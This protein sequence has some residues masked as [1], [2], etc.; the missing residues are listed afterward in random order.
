MKS[1]K[2]GLRRQSKERMKKRAVFVYTRI[3]P[4][5]YFSAQIAERDPKRH[6]KLADHIAHCSGSCCGNPRRWWNEP[7]MQERRAFCEE[8]SA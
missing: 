7:T 3:R 6:E 4:S 8:V 2:R 5:V 1:L